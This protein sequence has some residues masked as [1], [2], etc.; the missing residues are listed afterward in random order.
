MHNYRELYQPSNTLIGAG[1]I[2]RIPHYVRRMHCQKALVVSDEGLVK[3]GTVGKVLSVLDNSNAEY[4]LFTDVKPNPTIAIVNAGYKIALE[5]NCDYVIGIGGGSPL[6]VAKAIGILMTNGGD[7]RDYE[8]INQSSKRGLPIIAVNTTAGTGSEVTRDYVITD[9]EKKVKM[10]MVDYHCIASLAIDD[11]QLMTEMPSGLTAATGMD[12]LTHAIEAY[13]CK[14]HFP[15]SDGLALEA[16]RLVSTSL[17]KA[18]FNGNDLS[19]RTDMCWAEYMAG[20]AFSN[21]G[22][23]LVHAMAHQLGGFYN[24]PH[25]VANAILLPYVMEFNASDCKERFSAIAS[26]FGVNTANM[27]CDQAAYEAI[28]FIKKLSNTI[29]IPTLKKLGFRPEDALT[30]AINATNDTSITDNPKEASI[31]DIKAIFIKAYENV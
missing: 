8:G 18:V 29:G 26:A 28:H 9:E 27:T 20:L 23:G 12:A 19:A 10:L 24:M 31:P 14:S 4:V 6:D 13:V 2:N 1:A 17:E 16:I 7:I 5:H 30:L 11:P 3:I 22:L 15:Y 21:A 25:G